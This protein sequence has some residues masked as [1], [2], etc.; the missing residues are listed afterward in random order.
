AE[1][2]CRADEIAAMGASFMQ[3]V[4][5]GGQAVTKRLEGFE[6]KAEAIEQRLQARVESATTE[7]ADR[8]EEIRSLAADAEQHLLTVE[9]SGKAAERSLEART[10]SALADFELRSIAAKATL[11]ERCE[12]TISEVDAGSK[13]VERALEAHAESALAAFDLR[14]NAAKATLDERCRSTLSEVEAGGKAVERTLEAHMESAVAELERRSKE[15]KA[16]FD[17]AYES[18]VR[19]FEAAR[20][21]AETSLETRGESIGTEF[22]R[23]VA[24]LQSELEA[25]A[26]ELGAQLEVRAEDFDSEIRAAEITF[27]T[28][29]E[30]AIIELH[31]R[32]DD[33]RTSATAYA[34]ELRTSLDARVK[35]LDGIAER[36]EDRLTEVEANSRA[37]EKDLERRQTDVVAEIERCAID[38]RASLE[39]EG[40]DVRQRVVDLESLFGEMIDK[41]GVLVDS[42]HASSETLGSLRSELESAMERL[43]GI[44]SDM[45]GQRGLSDLVEVL[46]SRLDA[47]NEHLDAVASQ[48]ETLSGVEGLED[49]LG[50]RIG[51]VLEQSREAVADLG[52]RLAE[53]DGAASADTVE[54]LE[55]LLLEIGERVEASP[56]AEAVEALSHRVSDLA[57]RL[58]GVRAT[59]PTDV[60]QELDRRVRE[61]MDRL[62]GEGRKESEVRGR[63]AEIESQVSRVTEQVETE[64]ASAIESVLENHGATR[65]ALDSLEVRSSELSHELTAL[66]SADA[67]TGGAVAGDLASRVDT[68]ESQI[69][70]ALTRME[71]EIAP[72]IVRLDESIRVTDD[73]VQELEIADR[74]L[75][76]EIA[77]TRDVLAEGPSST[78][79]ESGQLARENLAS[80]MHAIEANR[81][82]IAE[83]RNGLG[84][85]PEMRE[86]L[87]D[88]ASRASAGHLADADTTMPLSESVASHVE[89]AVA[90]V[91]KRIEPA[92]EVLETQR[93]G[94][95]DAVGRME[96]QLQALQSQI[97]AALGHVETTSPAEPTPG[98][99]DGLT[100]TAR[101]ILDSPIGRR[102]KAFVAAINRGDRGVY[103]EFINSNYASASVSRMGL[104]Q[105]LAV[106][107]TLHTRSQGITI[108]HVEMI[109]DSQLRMVVR[110]N[111]GGWE[112]YVFA[113][114]GPEA[115]IESITVDP[116]EEDQALAYIRAA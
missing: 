56:G 108:R 39:I 60:I 17:T 61:L 66:R 79:A 51:E 13:A 21:S 73:A 33:A 100:A 67:E 25:R 94:A 76:I 54:S 89:A 2:S 47:T 95:E 31:R 71:S 102:V 80:V 34:E 30:A 97:D 101:S 58:D 59:E 86:R 116:I 104:D 50:S 6:G 111:A 103:A 49:R 43:S 69:I 1:V 46:G 27:D 68:L 110:T 42:R 81:A 15:A 48:L 87:S 113:A 35:E 29:Q 9:A 7:V 107:H 65:A 26:G 91:E 8:L 18:T 55:S 83:L 77:M 93:H 5:Q 78:N 98:A 109:G 41:V 36:T 45:R 74:D 90:K 96:Q 10:E 14:S 44:E 19:E 85:L 75:R 82:S 57:D 72:A 53:L 4:E 32:L 20:D 84:E 64:V 52:A 24:D 88:L 63:L 114:H 115:G 38:S 112:E 23:R 70:A 11:D 22:E 28:R 99:G 3:Q 37:A 12:A 62:D 16:E 105:R 40:E 92:L 106:F